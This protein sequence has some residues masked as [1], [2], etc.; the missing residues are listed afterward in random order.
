MNSTYAG[1]AGILSRGCASERHDLSFNVPALLASE[2]AK[3]GM[4]ILLQQRRYVPHW[5]AAAWAG[6]L[7]WSLLGHSH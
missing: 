5:R 1:I 3:L 2:C 7:S 6:D 4:N